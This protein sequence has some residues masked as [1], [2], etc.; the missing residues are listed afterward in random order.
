MKR[1]IFA[2]LLAGT[3]WGDGPRFGHKDRF[4]DQEFE[5]VYY[6]IGRASVQISSNTADIRSLQT[7][8]VESSAITSNVNLPATGTYGDLTSVELTAGSWLVFAQFRINAATGTG[9]TNFVAGV[10]T[11]SGNSSAGL[12]VGDNALEINTPALSA[13]ERR[14]VTLVPVY[15][16]V[17][18][19]TTYYLKMTA[20][21]TGGQPV[22]T[23]KLLAVRI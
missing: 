16:T 9:L 22:A 17:T 1:L 20:T 21:Y 6:D 2:L 23:G 11:T 18:N 19:T 5:N 3:A 12:S 4:V 14:T 13:N 8:D 10:S 15:A 7:A